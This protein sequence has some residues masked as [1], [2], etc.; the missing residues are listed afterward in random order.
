MKYR[1]PFF[2][3]LSIILVQLVFL[4]GC[5]QTSTDTNI[6]TA[7]VPSMTTD[8]Y[9]AITYTSTTGDVFSDDPFTPFAKNGSIF[10]IVTFYIENHGYTNFPIDQLNYVAIVNSISYQYYPNSPH[11]LSHPMGS[12]TTI[13]NGSKYIGTIVYE[14]PT[15]D[16]Q[17][18]F[19][20]VFSSSDS[21][22]FIWN[23]G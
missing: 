22:N 17:S 20:I 19:T 21:Y 9:I 7:A 18:G 10:L 1:N 5:H 12:G 13:L 11:Y 16:L 23:R 3:V 2:W 15:T 8:K 4:A 14:I 6:N